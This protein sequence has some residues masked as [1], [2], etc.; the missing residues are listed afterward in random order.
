MQVFCT[1]AEFFSKIGNVICIKLCMAYS[2][3]HYTPLV[4]VVLMVRENTL[5]LKAQC[6]KF[7][8]MKVKQISV[9]NE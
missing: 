6:G 5:P 1:C 8:R 2:I 7:M 4:L 9:L 3:T